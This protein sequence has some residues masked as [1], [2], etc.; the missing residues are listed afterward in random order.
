MPSADHRRRMRPGLLVLVLV[1]VLVVLAAAVLLVRGTT[2]TAP[3]SVEQLNRLRVVDRIIT[4]PTYRRAAFGTG[5]ADLDGDGCRTRDEVLLKTVDRSKPFTVQRQGRCPWD[6]VAGT[7]VDPY[8]AMVMTW[9]NLNQVNQAEGL[10]IDHIVSLAE[11]FRYGAKN[12][13]QQQRVAF[14]NDQENLT[15]TTQAVNRSKSDKDPATWSPP[16][17][18][19]CGYAS[20]YIAVKTRWNL[21]VD[22]Q[23]KN[24]LATMLDTCP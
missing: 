1:L 18:G 8:T 19:Q 15:P 4:D 5:W 13:T 23:Q 21:P 12:W 16:D 6:M 24:A 9:T 17:V 20:R 14:G 22:Q 11:A 7:W 2:Q 10:P 3:G